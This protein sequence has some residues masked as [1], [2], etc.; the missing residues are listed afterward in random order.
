MERRKKHN[1]GGNSENHMHPEQ[2]NTA[3]Y[4]AVEL[5]SVSQK[6]LF[7]TI[8][9]AQAQ[10]SRKACEDGRQPPHPLKYTTSAQKGT[11]TLL[12]TIPPE[13]FFAGFPRTRS[14]CIQHILS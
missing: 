8:T 2:D 11:N 6:L 10:K 7:Y 14:V 1:Q 5:F 9:L 13:T 12:I 3:P 4:V